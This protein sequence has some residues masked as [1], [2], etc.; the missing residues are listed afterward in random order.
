MS[1][2]NS[3]SLPGPPPQEQEESESVSS[4]ELSQ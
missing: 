2:F 4:F 3:P 1:M